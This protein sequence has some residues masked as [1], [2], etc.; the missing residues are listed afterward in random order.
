MTL[1]HY[2]FIRVLSLQKDFSIASSSRAASSHFWLCSSK[3]CFVS[4]VLAVK[5]RDVIA[6]FR[7]LGVP[8]EL[9]K[10]FRR[11]YIDS[12]WH[13]SPDQALL[14]CLKG[15]VPLS[16]PNGGFSSLHEATLSASVKL[17]RVFT[18]ANPQGLTSPFTGCSENHLQ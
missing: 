16:L 9:Q 18:V 5:F 3:E 7:Y 6:F 15:P 13:P 8:E 10:W 2:Y 4:F 12:E 11:L 14:P 1:H 17:L